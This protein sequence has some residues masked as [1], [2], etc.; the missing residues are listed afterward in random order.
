MLFREQITAADRN[1]PVAEGFAHAT[2][3]ARIMMIAMPLAKST[4]QSRSRTWA[5][6]PG[7]T[8]SFMFPGDLPRLPFPS[9]IDL[10]PV[11]N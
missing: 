1:V 4:S 5:T 8:G 3:Y 11:P 7:C 10:F 9:H 2:E 6:V